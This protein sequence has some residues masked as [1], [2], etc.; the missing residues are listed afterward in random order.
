MAEID[1]Q[2]QK[3]QILDEAQELVYKEGRSALVI[4]MGLFGSSVARELTRLG[5]FVLAVDGD[6]SKLNA[7]VNE[8]SSVRVINA[9][10][11]A[12]IQS[13]EPSTF[14]IC[15]S[16]IGDENAH[17]ITTAIHN[18]KQCDAQL[19]IARTTNRDHNIMFSKLGCDLI[20]E[21]EQTFGEAFSGLLHHMETAQVINDVKLD[22]SLDKLKKHH[23]ALVNTDEDP[24]KA[25]HS[26]PHI[27]LKVIQ[28]LIWG[29]LLQY[30][31]NL[32]TEIDT[33]NQKLGLDGQQ[34]STTNTYIMVMLILIT[35]WYLSSRIFT[36]QPTES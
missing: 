20:L 6:Q 15:I 17:V 36:A 9:V 26:R 3:P 12:I 35:L 21:P 1:T 33:L 32:S 10:D 31:Y 27:I 22:L 25:H 18:L 8:V 7:V 34:T 24:I 30:S 13:L 14:D 4:G 29:I 28:L 5:W 2:T 11:L 16:A 19:I 23:I